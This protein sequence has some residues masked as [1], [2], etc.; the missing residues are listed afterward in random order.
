MQSP[1]TTDLVRGISSHSCLEDRL[2]IGKSLEEKKERVVL[3]SFQNHQSRAGFREVY[4]VCGWNV[5][6]V[7]NIHYIDV[8]AQAVHNALK[9]ALQNGLDIVGLMRITTPD[10]NLSWSPE[11]RR[12]ASLSPSFPSL[13]KD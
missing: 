7:L 8:N 5:I 13:S 9:P 2:A 10:M 11:S 12:L 3:V 1:G 6:E 4:L